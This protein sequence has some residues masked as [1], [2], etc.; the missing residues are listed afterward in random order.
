MADRHCSNCGHELGDEERFCPSCGQPAHE[1]AHVPTPEADVQVPPPGHQPPPGTASPQN[2]GPP[3]QQGSWAGRSFG[4]GF[5]ASIGCTLGT[6]L[7]IVIACSLLFV[8]CALVVAIS[9]N[10]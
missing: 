2:E 5:G 7:G 3:R 9:S 8:G 10:A 1:T 6:C 4:G